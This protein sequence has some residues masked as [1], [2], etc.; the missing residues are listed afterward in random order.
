MI[1]VFLVPSFDWCGISFARATHEEKVE[2]PGTARGDTDRSGRPLMLTPGQSG[3]AHPCLAES[4]CG[5]HNLFLLRAA[6]F[7]STIQP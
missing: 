2:D 5:V 3:G 7:L 4:A 1:T 6:A